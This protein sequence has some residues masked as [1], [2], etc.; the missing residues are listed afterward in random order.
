MKILLLIIA[1]VGLT[2]CVGPGYA[3]FSTSDA[4]YHAVIELDVRYLADPMKGECFL[5]SALNGVLLDK[6][7]NRRVE[8]DERGKL[9]KV[10]VLIPAGHYDVSFGYFKN[11]MYLGGRDTWY[12]DVTKGVDFEHRI[13]RVNGTVEGDFASLW[14]EDETGKRITAPEKSLIKKNARPV[15]LVV[16]VL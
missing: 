7:T 5:V 10:F 15:H 8:R 3:T 4:Q 2:G 14:L 13:Y 1:V 11:A 12:A 16:P 9:S 6:F